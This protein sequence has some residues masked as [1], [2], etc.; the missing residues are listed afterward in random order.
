MLEFL[1]KYFQKNKPVKYQLRALYEK[2]EMYPIN[3]EKL[4]IQ[5]LTHSSYIKNLD[6][7]NERLE[8]LGDAVI[9]FAVAESHTAGKRRRHPDQGARHDR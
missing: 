9:N 6:E 8:F 7:R 4:Y 3:S 2:L 5:A 1:K